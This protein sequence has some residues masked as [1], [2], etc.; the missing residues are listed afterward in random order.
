[1]NQKLFL[2]WFLE[3]NFLMIEPGRGRLLLPP[4]GE[5][6]AALSLQA[7]DYQKIFLHIVTSMLLWFLHSGEV[8]ENVDK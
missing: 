6:R 5:V 7:E 4:V 3:S 1:M 2:L 8:P